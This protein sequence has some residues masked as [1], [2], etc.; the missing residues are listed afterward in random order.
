MTSM[1]RSRFLITG[2]ILAAV[3]VMLVACGGGGDG[4]EGPKIT[5]PAAV[6]TSTANPNPV[7]YV[8]KDGL[9]SVNGESATVAPNATATTAGGASTHVIESGDTCG[10]LAATWGVTVEAIIQ[11][12]RGVIDASCTNLLPGDTI[13]I[14]AKP[15]TPTPAPGTTTPR[16][17]PTPRGGTP[18]TGQTY[19]LQDGDTCSDIAERFGV[20][21]AAIIGANPGVIN[22]NCTNLFPGDVIKI[23]S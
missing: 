23:P 16:S 22:A 7:V 15:G 9:I 20:T 17:T 10:A 14:P 2:A 19:T 21:I 3:P 6:P 1:R 5:D 13:K 8:M 4:D 11:A 18:S 12:N